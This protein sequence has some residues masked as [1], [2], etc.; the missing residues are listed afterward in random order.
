MSGSKQFGEYGNFWDALTGQRAGIHY[1]IEPQTT[2]FERFQ[3]QEKEEQ[4][5]RWWKAQ[6]E[7]EEREISERL[8]ESRRRAGEAS[9]EQQRLD[10]ERFN[11]FKRG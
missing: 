9:A 5:H 10:E 8:E 6:R 4:E 2:M 11:L 3:K 1:S 7:K